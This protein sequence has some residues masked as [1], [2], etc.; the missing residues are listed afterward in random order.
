MPLF[1]YI[2]GKRM[3]FQLMS[4]AFSA[5]TDDA[6]DLPQCIRAGFAFQEQELQF[7]S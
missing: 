7:H 5:R 6:L 1:A 4:D 3:R 2:S